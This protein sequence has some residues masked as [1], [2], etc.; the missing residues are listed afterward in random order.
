M[1]SFHYYSPIIFQKI[2]YVVFFI[3]YKIFVRIE[4]RGRE[5]LL[6]LT[7]PI[8]LASNHTCELDVTAMPQVLPFFSPMWPIY[9]VAKP[10]E[11]YKTIG[12]RGYIYGGA[13]FSVLGGYSVYSGY[14][15]YS[16]S[17]ADF[18]VAL[19]SGSTVQIFPEGKCTRDGHMNPARGGLGF[20]AHATQATVVPIAIDTFFHMSWRE[21]FTRQRKVIITIGKPI[22]PQELFPQEPFLRGLSVS[23]YQSASQNV[24]DHIKILLAGH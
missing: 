5:N 19:K 21:F 7:G 9:Y 4:I 8:I 10:K 18:V 2:G 22:F 6:G 12:W 1:R 3:L 13:F 17:L 16:V 11:K 23:D 15:D 24:L 20:L 14:K